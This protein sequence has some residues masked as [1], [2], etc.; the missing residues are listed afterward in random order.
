MI[1]ILP[2]TNEQWKALHVLLGKEGNSSYPTQAV[3]SE[4]GSNLAPLAPQ[5]TPQGQNKKAAPGQQL[6]VE[7]TS[8]ESRAPKKDVI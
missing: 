2:E 5:R 3:K 8:E 1:A 7:G 6:C 4:L